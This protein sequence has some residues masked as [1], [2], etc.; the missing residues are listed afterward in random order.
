MSGHV[1]K[2]TTYYD[3]MRWAMALYGVEPFGRTRWLP[4]EI[5]DLFND[6]SELIRKE[7]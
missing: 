2:S 3:L 5:D 6:L 7:P 1:L 4:K